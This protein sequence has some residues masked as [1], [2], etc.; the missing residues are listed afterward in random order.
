VPTW[1]RCQERGV[2]DLRTHRAGYDAARVGTSISTTVSQADTCSAPGDQGVL[3]I[4]EKRSCRGGRSE[5][6]HSWRQWPVRSKCGETA[7]DAGEPALALVGGRRS[8][9]AFSGVTA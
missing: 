7:H 4:D 8:A 6:P 2:Y 9:C 3:A 1:Q 5:S